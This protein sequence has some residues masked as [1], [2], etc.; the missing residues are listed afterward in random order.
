MFVKSLHAMKFM[1]FR[2]VNPFQLDGMEIQGFLSA[3][4]PAFSMA[5]DQQYKIVLHARHKLRVPL[6]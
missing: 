4:L 1:R 3:K 2:I 5:Q 6:I